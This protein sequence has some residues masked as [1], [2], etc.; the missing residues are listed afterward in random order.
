MDLLIVYILLI[1]L[2]ESCA[3]YCFKRGVEHRSWFM[4]GVA[5]YGM[6]GFLLQKTFAHKGLAVVNAL[7]SGLSV[8]ATTGMGLFLFHEQLNWKDWAGMAAITAGVVL[9]KL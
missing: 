7:W 4:L 2:S 1:V 3:M 6:V 5:A 9:I 8:A